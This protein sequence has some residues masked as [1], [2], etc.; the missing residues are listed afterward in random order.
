MNDSSQGA[1]GSAPPAR[2][3]HEPIRTTASTRVVSGEQIST[4][5]LAIELPAEPL[6]R[7][8]GLG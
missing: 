7:A 8:S 3:S 4:A 1:K 5:T 6:E 2:N